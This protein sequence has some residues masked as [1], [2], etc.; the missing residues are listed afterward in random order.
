VISYLDPSG[1]LACPAWLA[2]AAPLSTADGPR[3]RLWGA[4][5][6]W[7]LKCGDTDPEMDGNWR[8]RWDGSPEPLRSIMWAEPVPVRDLRGL[9]WYAPRILDES[10]ARKFSVAYGRNWLPALTAQQSRA[11][12][13]AKAAK[14]AFDG[15]DDPGMPTCCQ[16]AAELLG[17][18]HPLCADAVAACAILDDSLALGVLSAAISTPLEFRD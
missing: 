12:E 10:G 15:A 18:C 5:D 17:V 4:G 6:P 2:G 7:L 8:C 9:T 3:G 16:W 14:A 11:L 1:T 13:I